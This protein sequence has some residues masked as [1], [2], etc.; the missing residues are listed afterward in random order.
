MKINLRFGI[1]MAYPVKESVL[2]FPPASVGIDRPRQ[3]LWQ[4]AMCFYVEHMDFSLI[5]TSAAHGIHEETS[6]RGGAA[7]A[8]YGGVIRAHGMRVQQEFIR[9]AAHFAT[10]YTP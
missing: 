4:F 1:A 3:A 6:V 5:L 7:H 8:H 10:I 2:I 9:A